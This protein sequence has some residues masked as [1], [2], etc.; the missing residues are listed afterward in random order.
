M[1]HIRSIYLV[2]F[3]KTLI[4]GYVIACSMQQMKASSC[5]KMVDLV[6]MVVMVVMVVALCG[7]GRV[8][9]GR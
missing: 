8:V 3:K 1:R 4:T 5:T 2:Y 9:G 7:V 6:V